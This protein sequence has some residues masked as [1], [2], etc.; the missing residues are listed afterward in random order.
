MTNAADWAP[1]G[2]EQTLS[3]RWFVADGWTYAGYARDGGYEALRKCLAMQPDEIIDQVKKSNLRGRGGAGFP[4]GM[5]WGFVPKESKVPKYLVINADESEPGTYKD[6]YILSRDPHLLLEGC[7]IG[8]K[9]IGANNIYIYIRGEFGLPYRRIENA[10]KEAYEKGIFG[11]S[12]MGSGYRIDCVVHR[13][14]GAYICGE[15]TA[16]LE[17]LEGK[18]GRPRLK[19]PFPA[20]KGAF[21]GPTS[22]NNVETV[23]CVPLI[24]SRGVDWFLKQGSPGNGGP[25]LMCVS[26]H[27][28]RPGIY[29]IPNGYPANKFLELCGGVWKGRKLKGIQPGGSSTPV[30]KPQPCKALAPEGTPEHMWP[31][32]TDTPLD[33]DNVKKAGSMFGSAGMM[34]FDD[35]TC[36]VRSLLTLGNFYAHESCGQCT[37]CREGTGWVAKILHKIEH[38]QGTDADI[39]KLLSATDYMMGMTICVLAD[40]IA[41]P[42]KSFFDKYR[43]EFMDHVRNHK[44]GFGDYAVEPTPYNFWEDATAER[45]S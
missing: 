16:L 23:A 10:V 5:K 15:E 42:V 22:V 7:A 43:D 19:P 33:F 26:G 39:A 13:G 21:A 45:A 37:P 14:A 25:K 40:S 35:Q 31:L 28:E 9:A 17:S 4:T 11:D 27:V 44:C 29:E 3:K 32:E 34:V 38:G 36:M 12:S 30:L 20:V 24:F 41:M 1:K 6:R 8:A 2:F 18:I